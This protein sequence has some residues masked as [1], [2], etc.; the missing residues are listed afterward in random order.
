MQSQ[1]LTEENACVCSSMVV[2]Y[3]LLLRELQ[4]PSS[5]IEN[6]LYRGQ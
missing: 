3:N 2:K 1:K 5:K 6:L 4:S